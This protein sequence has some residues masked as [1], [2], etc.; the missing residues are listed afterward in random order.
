MCPPPTPHQ[1]P[2]LT[3]SAAVQGNT[4]ARQ[5]QNME[6][7]DMDAANLSWDSHMEENLPPVG[8]NTADCV[9]CKVQIHISL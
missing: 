4:D 7:E 8:A 9:N 5:V 6:S 3:A 1:L 2:T